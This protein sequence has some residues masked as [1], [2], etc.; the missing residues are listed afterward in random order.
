[1]RGQLL[2]AC[3]ENV[4]NVQGRCPCEGA[5]TFAQVRVVRLADV[6]LK[7]IRHAGCQG[8]PMRFPLRLTRGPASRKDRP[9]ERE[10]QN[11]LDMI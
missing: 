9:Q 8:S 3:D 1:M 4:C 7:H 2:Q 6:T 11:A 5:T 10:P